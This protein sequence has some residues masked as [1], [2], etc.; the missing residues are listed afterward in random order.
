MARLAVLSTSKLEGAC[1]PTTTLPARAS[2]AVG[3]LCTPCSA[4]EMQA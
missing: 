4:V 1:P 2:A 3:E